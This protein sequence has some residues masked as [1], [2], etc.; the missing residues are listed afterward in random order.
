MTAILVRMTTGGAQPGRL[1]ATKGT[2]LRVET[3]SPQGP[4]V[5]KIERDALLA[6]LN[7]TVA[8]LEEAEALARLAQARVTHADLDAAW[9]LCAE[10]PTGVGELA[11]LL[12]GE[13]TPTT[14]DLVM[15]AIALD[16]D[17]F[18]LERGQV[19]R[20]TAAQRQALQEQ[21]QA[22]ARQSIEIAPFLTQI[23]G[24]RLGRQIPARDLAWTQR[25]EAFVRARDLQ[26]PA[27]ALLLRQ[28]SRTGTTSPRDAADLLRELGV[29]DAHDDLELLRSG[30]CDPWPREV[31]ESLA[32]Q[33]TVGRDI[34]RLDLPFL[35][36]DNDAPHE[37]DDA[38]WAVKE[39]DGWRLWVAIASPSCWLPPG[40][41]GDREAN[42]R[43]AT[44]YHPR[45]V[46][47]MLPDELARER[48]SL[49]PGVW[50][51]AI[52]FEVGLDAQGRMRDGSVREAEVR[53][54]AA[55]S[56]D[57]VDAAL[58]DETPVAA[59]ATATDLR[60]AEQIATLRT[61]L[62]AC[63]AAEA[64]RISNGA[65]LLYKP[66]VEVK[67]PRHKALELHNSS[68]TSPARRLVTEAMVLC[69]AQ[70]A[71]FCVVERLAVP[72]RSQPRPNQ[73][74]L[75]P[76][77]Y[78]DPADIHSILRTLQPTRTLTQPE[79]HG[80]LALPAYV[81]VS[82]PLR[83]FGDLV[84]H[85]QILAHL[86]GQRAPYTAQEV[87]ARMVEAEA[88]QTD[89]RQWQRRGDRYFKLLWLAGRGIGMRLDAQL[90]R[91]LAHGQWLAFVP[92]LALEVPVHAAGGQAG[93]AV[94]LTVRGIHPGTGE[95][96][97]HVS[98][99]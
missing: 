18:A 23:D 63:R 26:D 48:A 82:S 69:C 32:E 62:D 56:Y 67:A 53:I 64:E 66:D 7:T 42:R 31:V 57:R 25:L 92:V 12:L 41:T 65:Y 40:S 71:K 39:A 78:T 61:L 14:R 30:V 79:P 44:L 97:V 34:Q 11:Q 98:S 21:R 58:L 10:R 94:V 24:I 36:L 91:S 74:P 17:A 45:Y 85:R 72:F 60:R 28:R 22:E 81:Q 5:R 19:E 33:P 29:W 86:R 52:V 88:G 84:A 46:A 95:L 13:Q 51:P 87:A 20:R 89:R 35:T 68:Q 8:T 2:Q 55:W 96:Q 99:P 47:G 59:E 54:E 80:V 4:E 49:L 70:A 90:V 76:G 50:Q 77:L 6:T 15:L 27:M 75:P 38:L 3:R 1:L 83:R 9:A 73:P 16:D 37:V 43:G 93:D